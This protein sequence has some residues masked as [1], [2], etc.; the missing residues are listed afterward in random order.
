M[1]T[2]IIAALV[3][4]L[5]LGGLDITLG[6]NLLWA[7]GCKISRFVVL[8]LSGCINQAVYDAL[9]SKG[10]SAP[11]SIVYLSPPHR[12]DGWGKL[13]RHPLSWHRLLGGA[14]TR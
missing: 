12:L 4:V 14:L 11:M 3:C 8:N 6:R 10:S 1:R 5:W 13:G 2:S 7:V 9:K